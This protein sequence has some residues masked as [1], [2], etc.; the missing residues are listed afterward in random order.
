[1]V[2]AGH[3]GQRQT[4]G[5]SARAWRQIGGRLRAACR[6]ARARRRARSGIIRAMAEELLERVLREIRERRQAAQAA[7]DESRRLERALAA[8]DAPSGG[9]TRERDGAS[10][11]R[12]VRPR[13]PRTAS[14]AKRSG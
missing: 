2:A 13:R 1:M 4:S 7:Y 14:G 6:R 11:R 3:A 8:L 10:S 12:R 9:S 5:S